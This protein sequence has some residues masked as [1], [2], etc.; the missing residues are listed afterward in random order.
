VGLAAAAARLDVR[1]VD[2]EA[3]AQHLV[4]DV[5]DLGAAEIGRAVLFDVDLDAL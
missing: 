1:V 5:V 4:V 2:L 3:R